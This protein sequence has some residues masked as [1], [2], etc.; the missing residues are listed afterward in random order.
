MAHTHIIAQIVAS[1]GTKKQRRY[2]KR[3]KPIRKKGNLLLCTLLLGNVAV[4]SGISILLSDITTGI[5]G[6]LVSTALITMLG[7]IIPQAVCSRYALL[8]GANTVW[9]VWIVLVVLLPISLPISFVLDCVLGKEVGTVFK[10]EELKRLVEIHAEIE[11]G[12]LRRDEAKI[13]GGVLEYSKKS[14]QDVMTP[15]KDVFMLELSE[16]LDYEVMTMIWEEG[17]SRVPVYQKE[18]NNIIGLLFAKDLLLISPD[19]ELPLSTV[20][21]FYGRE[22]IK[23]F[24]DTHLDEVLKL[25]KTGK[26]HLA[27]VH[28][29]VQP[30]DGD[31][32]YETLGIAT[33]EDVIEEILK[34]EIVDETDKYYDNQTFG[35]IDRSQQGVRDFSMISKKGRQQRLTMK[36]VNTVASFLSKSIDVFALVPEEYLQSMLAKCAV[37]S[38]DPSKTHDEIYLYRKGVE[39]NMFTLVLHG[40]LEVT[41]GVDNFV[42]DFGSWSFLGVRALKQ[43]QFVPDFDARVVKPSRLLQINTNDLVQMLNK[44]FLEDD[45]FFLPE[46]MDWIRIHADGVTSSNLVAGPDKDQ[47][48]SS[49]STGSSSS[50]PQPVTDPSPELEQQDNDAENSSSKDDSIHDNNREGSD[51]EGLK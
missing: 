29:A 7:E 1:S 47:G 10:R 50:A 22:V 30:D 13:L 27:I 14:I 25:F 42:S 6:F 45:R 24:P 41:T 40:K 35:V 51:D 20:L 39:S 23:I 8:I 12:S 48:V 15:I 18:K 16:K 11:G 4:N 31:P 26:S 46:D 34:D 32:Y 21:N 3:I 43:P 36:Q 9:I 19:D 28:H 5:I 33:L 49:Q 17:H 37:Y 38:F 2:A 44:V